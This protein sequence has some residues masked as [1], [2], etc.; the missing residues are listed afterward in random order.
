MTKENHKE[1]HNFLKLYANRKT[2]PFGDKP[3]E[4]KDIRDL[5]SYEIQMQ[6]CR[7][8]SFLKMSKLE[9]SLVVMQL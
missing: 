2:K 7:L 6:I 1:V 3:I 5:K 8:M 9:L 4:I